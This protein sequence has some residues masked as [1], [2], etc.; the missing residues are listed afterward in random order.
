MTMTR[1]LEAVARVIRAATAELEHALDEM[2]HLTPEDGRSGSGDPIACESV[3]DL[4]ERQLEVLAL[5][6][7]GRSNLAIARRLSLTEKT[8]EAHVSSI[9]SI[10]GLPPGREHHRRVLAVLAYLGSRHGRAHG[11]DRFGTPDVA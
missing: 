6:A 3:A 7:E 9:L 2:H 10:L 1:Q 5:M 8:V 4:S 11:G